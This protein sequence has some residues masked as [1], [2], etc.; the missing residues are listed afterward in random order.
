MAVANVFSFGGISSNSYGVVIDGD[1]DYSAPKRDVEAVT[2][3]GRNGELL[4]DQG[5]WENIEV[6]YNCAIQAST[7][8]EFNESVKD[9]RNAIVSK[10]GYQRLMDTYHPSEFRYAAYASGFDKEPEFH[11]KTAIFEVKFNCMPQRFLM[12]GEVTQS[13]AS[14]NTI[15]NPTPYEAQ[16]LIEVTGYGAI[17]VNGYDIQMNDAVFGIV[18]LKNQFSGA[19]T[20]TIK[21]NNVS[22]NGD[23]ITVSF[24][25][26]VRV[27][28]TKAGDVSLSSYSGDTTLVSSG[29][30]IATLQFEGTVTFTKGTS[31][32]RSV[33]GDFVLAYTRRSDSAT[34]NIGGNVGMRVE[35]N[36]SRDTITTHPIP[37]GSSQTSGVAGTITRTNSSLVTNSIVVD[38]S[39]S[40]LGNPTYIDCEIGEAYKIEGGKIVSLNKYIDLGSDPPVLSVGSNDVTYD[41]TVT[42]LKIKPR[43]WI[44]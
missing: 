35:Y 36:A 33:Q 21:A 42:S 38:S 11:G 3:P 7:Q 5:R 20:V 16:P 27:H 24:T 37:Q 10:I 26:K 41:N 43:W 15:Y 19:R 18:T 44:L 14:G 31:E 39:K 30:L 8:S 29:G 2:I 32:T 9:F 17:N 13:I 40:I 22:N 6:T 12:N 25:S 34:Q 23:I 1:G 28:W 4:L